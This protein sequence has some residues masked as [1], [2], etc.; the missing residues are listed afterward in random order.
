[1]YRKEHLGNLPPVRV[2]HKLLEIALQ[3]CKKED[4]T[5]ATKAL[6]ELTLAL[7]F[8]YQDIAL[9]FFRLYDY[10]KQCVHKG[11]FADAIAI[12]EDLRATWAQAFHLKEAA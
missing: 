12:L 10:C 8:E 1:M 5:L 4:K 11:N 2:I 6:T 3:G 7:N 9:G